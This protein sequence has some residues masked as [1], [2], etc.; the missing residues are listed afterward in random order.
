MGD[1]LQGREY[2]HRQLQAVG[3]PGQ[4]ATYGMG[5]SRAWSREAMVEGVAYSRGS[6]IDTHTQ[7][8]CMVRL[9]RSR[10]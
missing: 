5:L 1:Y 8:R 4:S 9:P 3:A 2:I 6:N 10:L 7:T